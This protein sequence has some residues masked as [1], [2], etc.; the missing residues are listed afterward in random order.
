MKRLVLFPSIISIMIIAALTGCEKEP[1]SSEIIGEWKL[2]EVLYI[3]TTVTTDGGYPW[4]KIDYSENNLIYDFRKNNRLVIT[5]ST[6]GKL[7]ESKCSYKYE[8]IGPIIFGLLEGSLRIRKTE[9]ICRISIEEEMTIHGFDK[10]KKAIDEIDL[11][12]MEQDNLMG[13]T[14]VFVKLN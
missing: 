12:M 3:D 10:S 8:N 9:Y 1:Y 2:V 5:S 13:W 11:K 6:P 7:Q 4:L 14:K